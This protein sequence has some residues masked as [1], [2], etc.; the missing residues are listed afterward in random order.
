MQFLVQMQLKELITG[1]NL[2]S[3]IHLDTAYLMLNSIWKLVKL[4][5]I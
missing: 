5:T 4:T 3:F 1:I 2:I